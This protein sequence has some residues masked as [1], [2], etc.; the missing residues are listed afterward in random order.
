MTVN[1]VLLFTK[2]KLYSM[3]NLFDQ[4]L[5]QIQTS[6]KGKRILFAC[7]PADGHFNPLTGIAVHLQKIGYD[8]RWYTSATFSEKLAKLNI[9]HY[10]FQKALEINGDNI[11]EKFPDRKKAKSMIAKLNFD[12]KNFFID[13]APEYF[14]DIKAIHQSFPFDLFVADCAFTAIAFVEQKLGIPAIAMGI[15][16]LLAKS[17]DL[18]PYGL[19]MVPS[20]TF[21][22]KIKQRTLHWVAKN[23]LFKPSNKAL[24]E[25]C[26]EH[27]LSYE[28][29]D[30][31]NYNLD[32]SSVFLQS[33]TPG[34]EYERSD[35]PA[36]VHYVGALLPYAKPLANQPW[37]DARLNKYDKVILV[38]QGT[39]EKDVTKLIKPTLEA[40]KNSDTLVVVTTAGAQT[41]ELRAAYNYD[42]IIIEDFIP[43]A[44]VMPYVDVYVTNGGYGG[45]LLGIQNELPLVV[46]GLHEGKSEICARVGYFN[47]GINLKTERPIPRQ[48][49]NSVEAIL[50][51]PVYKQN[52]SRLAQEFSQYNAGE[53]TAS[54]VKRLTEEKAGKSELRRSTVLL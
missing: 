16:P 30:V 19:G 41:Q 12:L 52:V 7:V 36:R 18:A 47:L 39:A 35:V 49:K 1:I 5:H 14:E 8:V 54:F 25:L 46:A 50:A 9:P 45:T 13:R 3:K 26:A 21:F 4:Q 23:F 44:E 34:F 51:N 24:K 17:K 33:A 6:A 28:G 11:D 37:F 20:T 15:I 31:F 22:G 42:N 48:I 53:L 38:T 43:Y 40:F 32:K 27:Q 10:P 29:Q 2:P